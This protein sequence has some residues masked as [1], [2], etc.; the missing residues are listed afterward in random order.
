MEQ[1][2]W[3]TDSRLEGQEIHHILC[4]TQ[5]HY[6]VQKNMPLDHVLSQLNPVHTLTSF[7]LFSCIVSE[8]KL[9]FNN[10]LAA[11]FYVQPYRDIW[12]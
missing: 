7:H 12:C 4:S 2:H 11:N 10:S 9:Y 3:E 5:V 1:N 8:S 6:R